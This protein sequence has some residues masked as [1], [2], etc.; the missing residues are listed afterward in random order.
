[1]SKWLH[2]QGCEVVC[3][4]NGKIGL[5]LLK[6]KQFDVAFIDFLMVR[7]ALFDYIIRENSLYKSH[8][9]ADIK[10]FMFM[11]VIIFLTLLYHFSNISYQHLHVV[12]YDVACHVRSGDNTGAAPVVLYNESP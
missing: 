6:T 4:V 10:S 5:E 12:R 7:N 2:G 1:M 3:A 11:H 9:K 8:M